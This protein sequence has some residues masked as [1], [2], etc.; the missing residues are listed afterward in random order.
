MISDE[1]AGMVATLPD[2]PRER[3]RRLAEETAGIA[4]LAR[5]LAAALA[6][7]A[8]GAA[9]LEGWGLV[10]QAADTLER[11]LAAPGSMSATALTAAAYEL[12]SLAAPA[13][14]APAPPAPAP[15]VPLTSLR[16]RT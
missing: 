5:S 1:L 12:D 10:A 3:V 6:R 14:T 15:D 8:D 9:P 4:A 11:A 2:L 16:R 13:A 7:Y